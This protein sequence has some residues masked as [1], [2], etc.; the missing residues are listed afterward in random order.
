MATVRET[1]VFDGRLVTIFDYDD[2]EWEGTAPNEAFEEVADMQVISTKVRNEGE[3]DEWLE[4]V[5][6]YNYDDDDPDLEGM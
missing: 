2:L 3:I 4:V 6:C 5:A 1:V